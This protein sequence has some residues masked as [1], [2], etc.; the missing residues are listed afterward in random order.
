[1]SQAVE[2]QRIATVVRYLLKDRLTNAMRPCFGPEMSSRRLHV[3]I[4]LAVDVATWWPYGHRMR[5]WL[6]GA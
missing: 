2:Q 5:V 3:D 6:E 1:M 4:E